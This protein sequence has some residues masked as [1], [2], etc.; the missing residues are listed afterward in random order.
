MMEN[1]TLIVEFIDREDELAQIGSAIQTWGSKRTICITGDGGIG[2]TRLVSEIR[3]RYK[4][5]PIKFDDALNEP[6]LTI[7]LVQEFTE[8]GWS[9]ELLSGAHKMAEDLGINLVEFDAQFDITKMVSQMEQAIALKPDA[10]ILR[11][12]THNELLPLLGRALDE[13]IK[14]VS[15][16]NYLPENRI[17]T[18]IIQDY[19]DSDVQLAQQLVLDMGGKG[20]VLVIYDKSKKL[21][22]NR[23]QILKDVLLAYPEIQLVDQYV[24]VYS[25]QTE[26]IH[27]NTLEALQQDA[28]IKAIWGAWDEYTDPALKAIEEA[29]RD[30]VFIYGYGLLEEQ[31]GTMLAT[32]SHWKM[33]VDSCPSE[34]GKYVIS[35]ATMVALNEPVARRYPFKTEVIDCAFLKTKLVDGKLPTDWLKLDLHWTARLNRRQNAFSRER[36]L[37]PPLPIFDFDDYANHASQNII[38]QILFELD[39]EG[40]DLYRSE[41]GVYI[42]ET[43]EIETEPDKEKFEDLFNATSKTSRILLCFDTVD[44]PNRISIL[45]EVYKSF[46]NLGNFVCIVA[47]RLVREFYKQLK[48]NQ[49]W[50][51]HTEK[52]DL[53]PLEKKFGVEYLR[54]KQDIL[55]VKMDPALEQN[56]LILASGRPI[57][58]DLA[59][60][61]LARDIPLKWL[62]D[63][64][65]EK[66]EAE[67]GGPGRECRIK[68]FE[69]QLIRHIGDGRRELDWLFLIMARIYPLDIP[70]IEKL[71]KMNRQQ[72]EKLFEEARSYTFV[73]SLPNG[74]IK[75]HDV[76]QDM[77]GKLWEEI[78]PENDRRKRDSQ[79]AVGYYNGRIHEID[80][81]LEKE[82]AESPIQR[83]KLLQELATVRGQ[84]LQH[85]FYID[86]EQA[87]RQFK[88]MFEKDTRSGRF[89]SRQV[90]LDSISPYIDNLSFGDRYHIQTRMARHLID[91]RQYPQAREI[92]DVLFHSST[93]TAEQ[94]LG[95]LTNEAKYF[96]QIGDLQAADQSLEKAEDICA[97]TPNLSSQH[98]GTIL[99]TRGWVYRQMGRH[100]VAAGYYEQALEQAKD[101]LKVAAILNNVGYVYSLDG[102]YEAALQC[103]ESSMNLRM[104]HKDYHGEGMSCATLGDIYRNKGD[105]PQAI[106]YFNK[107]IDIFKPEKDITWMS[108]TYSRRGAVKRLMDQLA[109]A[110]ADLAESIALNVPKELPWAYHV[111]GCVSWN[112]G[113]L[114]DAL[115]LFERS[116]HAAKNSHDI[117]TQVNNLVGSAEVFYQ[118]W[119]RSAMQTPN[120]LENI[121]EKVEALNA[122]LKQEYDFPHHHGRIL[123]VLADVAFAEQDYEKAKKLYADAY[124]LLGRRTA[125]YGKRNFNQ[126][127]QHIEDCILHIANMDNQPQTALDWCKYFKKYWTDRQGE[128][129]QAEGLIT[130]CTMLETKIRLK[131]PNLGVQHA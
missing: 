72:A 76:M 21:Q 89:S 14:I 97:N 64:D 1:Q 69:Y 34:V 57:L 87:T 119:I 44:D 7:A 100:K 18:R 32:D 59:V 40:Y 17:T 125:G 16:D 103:C 90:L 36:R 60:D 9:H 45:L 113:R 121:N 123:R 29:E 95:L 33:T 65:P 83:E 12:G 5:L 130:K 30:D 120:L 66:L 48:S 75:L 68:E 92:L 74:R 80:V 79:M 85:L 112:E 91:R 110:R 88:E 61:W 126:E 104:E 4:A 118:M 107:A 54:K 58:I 8:T 28:Q 25:N 41:D 77:I 35:I 122:L 106:D 49:D 108:Y 13:G 6:K 2:K 101:P 128:I 78:D 56:L 10:L 86:F 15:F 27:R 63:V 94:E 111:M 11:L 55:G 39:S 129:L 62:K 47:G 67:M 84:Y 117:H 26:E 23:H 93:L 105:Y 96:I 20:K 37:F 124:A 52:I 42:E 98:F 131:T 31:V 81:A 24:D 43:D 73:K 50:K 109:D 38:A 115:Q 114:D 3:Q 82:G 22:T 51:E 116:Q 71:R 70:M 127:L 99:N 53:K 46:Q 102:K 19:F